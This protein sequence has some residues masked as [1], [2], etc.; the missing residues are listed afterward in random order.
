M[1]SGLKETK[2]KKKGIGLRYAL[3]GVNF[4][5]AEEKNFKIHSLSAVCVILLGFLFRLSN[6]EWLFLMFSITIVFVTEM[7][8]SA[9]ES[10]VD[11][12]YPHYHPIAG[13]VKDIA[14]GSVLIAAIGAAI[15]GFI[16][17]VP[18]IIFLIF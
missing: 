3:K 18:K 2:K 6:T 10:L 16:I 11:E 14:A 13:K 9:F 12:L 17:F 1:S 7:L 8:N 15:T 5:W 4:V